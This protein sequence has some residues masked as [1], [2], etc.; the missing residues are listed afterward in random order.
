MFSTA[1]QLIFPNN[2]GLEHVCIASAVLKINLQPQKRQHIDSLNQ[3]QKK[4]IEN[5]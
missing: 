2:F 4:L 3:R 1:G 5:A